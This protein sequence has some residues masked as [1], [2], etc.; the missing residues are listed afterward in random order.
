M[1]SN[2]IFQDPTLL[3]SAHF[4]ATSLLHASR[5]AE[6]CAG[7]HQ[8]LNYLMEIGMH[9]IDALAVRLVRPVHVPNDIARE[10]D[11]LYPSNPLIDVRYHWSEKMAIGGYDLAQI[12]KKCVIDVV[13]SRRAVPRSVSVV[14]PSTFRV[15][16]NCRVDGHGPPVRSDLRRQNR[17]RDH[18]NEVLNRVQLPVHPL[19]DVLPSSV[20]AAGVEGIA[21][22][23]VRAWHLDR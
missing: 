23:V 15:S 18:A 2:L 16:L 13:F 19:P 3:F 17:M 9:D 11:L 8:L 1:G 6:A 5:D 14:G 20:D 22:E 10:T 12:R 4:L 21:S 7:S